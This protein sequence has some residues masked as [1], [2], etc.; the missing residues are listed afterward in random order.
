M[1]RT[2]VFP[3]TSARVL[4]DPSFHDSLIYAIAL[5]DD[6]KHR[7][8]VVKIRDCN[9]MPFEIY[10][11]DLRHLRLD[12]FLT[13]NVI[14][15]LELVAAREV[16]DGYLEEFISTMKVQDLHAAAIADELLYFAIIPANGCSLRALCKD[17]LFYQMK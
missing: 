11:S 14:Y 13:Q 12:R 5:D 9:D 1:N 8:L 10:L 6:S 15:E 16:E 17:V 2:P 3:T 7:S 4:R